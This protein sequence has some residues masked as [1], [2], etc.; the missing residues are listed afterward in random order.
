MFNHILLL[1]VLA[2]NTGGNGALG[3][4]GVEM[5]GRSLSVVLSYPLYP[6]WFCSRGF[7]PWWYRF[8][9]FVFVLCTV[10]YVGVLTWCFFGG[11]GG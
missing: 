5:L 2:V 8:G 3:R 10:F 9:V 11:G 6:G 7:V 1:T 4:R